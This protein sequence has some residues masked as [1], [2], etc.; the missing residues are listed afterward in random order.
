MAR[1]S[2]RPSTP[3][4]P[5]NAASLNGKEHEEGTDAFLPTQV[6]FRDYDT[7]DLSID[8]E[9]YVVISSKHILLKWQA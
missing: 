7:T 2:R 1:Y 4:T 8:G 6:K 5:S 3:E 9:E